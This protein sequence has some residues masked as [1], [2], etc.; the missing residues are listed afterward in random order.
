MH[1]FSLC[2][3]I[4]K[5]VAKAN[6]NNLDNVD[7]VIIEIGALANVDTQSLC[8]WFPV[9]AKNMSCSHI[10]LTVDQV[11]GLAL[12]KSCKCQFNLSNLYEQCPECH[13]FGNYDLIQGQEL[14]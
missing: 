5:Q 14:L 3:G 9:V 10:K 6:Q 4:I 7:E 2:D 1:E 12:C 11:G 13:E 8:F